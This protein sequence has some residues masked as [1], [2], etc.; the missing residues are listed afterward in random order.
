[1]HRSSKQ[2]T[3][4]PFSGNGVCSR[5]LLGKVVAANSFLGLGWLKTRDE[6]SPGRGG[7]SKKGILKSQEQREADRKEVLYF[8]GLQPTEPLLP[9]LGH[10]LV[11]RK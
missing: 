6:D 5:T 3:T 10:Q 11:L 1:M 2:T 8:H 7:R 9:T 4:V